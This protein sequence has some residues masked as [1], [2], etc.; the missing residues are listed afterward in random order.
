MID[1]VHL[2]GLVG[3]ALIVVR[4]SLFARVRRYVPF[5]GCAQCVGF[6][7]GFWPTVLSFAAPEHSV[8]PAVVFER[9][10]HA[11]LVGGAVSLL[12]SLAEAALAALDEV[13]LK[14]QGKPPPVA[15]RD[16]SPRETA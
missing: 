3:A 4:S 10:W 6:H 16:K 1:P 8:P 12:S 15:L 11:L 13:V 7:A 2:I 14:L 9:F 5:L